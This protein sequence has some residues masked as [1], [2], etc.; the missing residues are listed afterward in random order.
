[1]NMAMAFLSP[2]Q[3]SLLESISRLG[4]AN[5]FLPERVDLERAALGAA[6]HEGEPVWSYRA[7]QLGTRINVVRIQ[8]VLEP[9]AEDLRA[10]LEESTATGAEL[11]L[12]EDAVLH[13]LFL[14]YHPR[15]FEAAFE[16][17]AD[18]AN[19][20]R[21]RF[22]NQFLADWRRFFQIDG[23][24]FP[25]GHDP[26]HMFAC[27]RQIQRAFELVFRDIIGSSL[28]AA[29]LRGAI[30]QSIFTHDMRRYRRTLYARMG[31]FATLI[32]GPSGTGEGT[33]RAG[34]RR[35]ALCALRRPETVV[36]Q[37]CRG[38]PSDQ[39]FGALAHAGGIGAVRAPARI[40]HRGY[41]RPQG[42][43]GNLPSWGRCFWTSWATW[44]RPSR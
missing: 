25:S 5:P 38:L 7:D 11:A 12:Y 6:F 2:S 42:V 37:R 21:W 4:Y 19:P 24:R 35:F 43:A 34:H 44:T 20:A 31:E 33:G 22:Y 9:L 16:T 28:A 10:R 27:F 1:M 14:R 17:Q 32:T 15:F 18:K 39:H 30:W 36:F 41:R 23:V 3:R 13:M 29:R 40:V 8:Q 26:R